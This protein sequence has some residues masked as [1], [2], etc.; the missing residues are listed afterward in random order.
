MDSADPSPAA[1][2]AAGET[3]AVEEGDTLSQIALE[4]LGD[5]DRYPEIFE[6]SRKIEQPGH[7]HLTDPDLIRPGWTL[8]ISAAEPASAP[9]AP[10]AAPSGRRPR[11]RPRACR[12][13]RRRPRLPCRRPRRRLRPPSV[14]AAAEEIQGEDSAWMVR[15]GY[16]VGAV[17]AAGVLALVAGRRR[18][19]QRRRKPG[20]RVPLP[21]GPAAQVEQ[22]L[23]VTADQLSV[24][25]VD[26][27]LRGLA[28]TAPRPAPPSPWLAPPD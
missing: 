26:R 7:A 15:T 10:E 20:Q 22:E 13:P 23:R 1:R 12:R 9:A 21:Q 28:Q 25:T 8:K 5:A 24:D 4:Q 27:A 3:V 14:P 17:L 11:R 18:T 2:S 16:G 6:A 19:Q